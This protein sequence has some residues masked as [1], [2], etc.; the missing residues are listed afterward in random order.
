MIKLDE[1]DIKAV[2]DSRFSRKTTKFL[3]GLPLGCCAVLV[4]LVYLAG[5]SG[6]PSW[7]LFIPII[8]LLAGIIW[9]DAK[10]RA[11]EKALVE[12]WKKDA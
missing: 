8:A 9:W 2:A 1:K 11:A 4:L 5:D 3:V 7:L 10:R 12:E 6:I